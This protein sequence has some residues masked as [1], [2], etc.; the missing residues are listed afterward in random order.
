MIAED[1]G[2]IILS[3]CDAIVNTVNCVGVMGKGLALQFKTAFPSNYRAYKNACNLNMVKPGKC[4]VFDTKGIKPRFIINFPTKR[5]WRDN[6]LL[7]DIESGLDDLVYQ[8]G[9]NVILSIAIPPLGCGLGGLSWN[10]VKP[11][12]VNKL[13]DIPVDVVLFCPKQ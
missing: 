12:I 9:K 10:V 11:I 5:H 1:R 3:S 7:E 2:N 6:S 4:F 13:K 8:I